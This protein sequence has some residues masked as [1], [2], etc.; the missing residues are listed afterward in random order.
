MEEDYLTPVQLAQRLRLNYYTVMRWIHTGALEA[1]P[2]REG[3]RFRYHIKKSVVE[4]IEQRA[5]HQQIV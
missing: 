1:E 4:A 2:I 5:K 3:K